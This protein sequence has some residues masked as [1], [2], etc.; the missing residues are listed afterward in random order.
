MKDGKSVKINTTTAMPKPSVLADTLN[1]MNEYD[2]NDM[3]D[4]ITKR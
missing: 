1:T 3:N 4:P 2:M